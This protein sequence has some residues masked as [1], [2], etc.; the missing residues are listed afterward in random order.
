MISVRAG[1]LAIFRSQLCKQLT[2]DKVIGAFVKILVALCIIFMN[3]AAKS[4]RIQLDVVLCQFFCERH[5]SLQKN[6]CPI[7]ER[8]HERA[9]QV[10]ENMVKCRIFHWAFVYPDGEFS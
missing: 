7:F 8:M 4:Y 5:I 6:G 2:Q 3:A 10:K 9:A 1:S